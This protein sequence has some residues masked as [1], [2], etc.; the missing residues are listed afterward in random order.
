MRRLT[1]VVVGLFI[2][3]YF[4]VVLTPLPQVIG[5][6]SPELAAFLTPPT[7]NF[8]HSYTTGAVLGLNIGASRA[9]LNVLLEK[10]FG[11]SAILIPTCGLGNVGRIGPAVRVSSQEAASLLER[12]QVCLHLPHRHIVLIAHLGHDVITR[13]EITRVTVGL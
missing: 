3:I 5:R 11:E 12:N 13:I 9:E 7:F 4:V 2:V 6:R 8:H 10:K 1:L